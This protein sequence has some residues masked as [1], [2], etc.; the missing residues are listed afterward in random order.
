MKLHIVGTDG[1]NKSGFRVH[2]F[3]KGTPNQLLS[4]PCVPA[5]FNLII[6]KILRI[7]PTRIQ[8]RSEGNARTETRLSEPEKGICG[9]MLLFSLLNK[10]RQDKIRQG[11]TSQDESTQDKTNHMRHDEPR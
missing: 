5:G 4:K 8:S 2:G 9:F 6:K 7:L 1:F 11:K 3:N 10:T